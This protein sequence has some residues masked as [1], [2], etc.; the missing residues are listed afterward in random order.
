MT[1]LDPDRPH[2]L[3]A[4][5]GGWL[6]LAVAAWLVVGALARLAL[7]VRSPRDTAATSAP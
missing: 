6:V 7:T 4:W 2:R 1:N 3:A 5:G